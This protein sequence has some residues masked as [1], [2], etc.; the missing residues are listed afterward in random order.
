[1]LSVDDDDDSKLNWIFTFLIAHI[2]A[3]TYPILSYYRFV[4][5]LILSAELRENIYN[6]YFT[7]MY[8]IQTVNYT[9]FFYNL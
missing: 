2:C 1:M 4:F 8:V 7:E 9:V 5:C 6:F 3:C